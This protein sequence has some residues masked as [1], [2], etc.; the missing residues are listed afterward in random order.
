[1][2]LKPHPALIPSNVKYVV[3]CDESGAGETFGSMFLGC[4]AI[5]AEKLQ[6]IKQIFDNPNIKELEEFEIQDKYE[7]IRKDCELFHTKCKATEI[8]RVGKNTLL[9]QKYEELI[10][11]ATSGKED[12]CIIID[13]YG[14]KRGL[15]SFLDRLQSDGNTIIVENRADEK[16]AACQ[17]ASV[18]ARKERLEEVQSNNEKYKIRDES[19]KIIYPDSGNAGNPQTREYLE[20]FM[21]IHPKKELPSF[22]RKKWS[23]V[24]KLLQEKSNQKISEFFEG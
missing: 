23:N 5:E 9:D 17:A 1:M 3:G 19:G 13:D 18:I 7:Q 14:V 21:R 8:D 22:V 15:K 11:C 12:A 2:K 4:V 10:T 6:N 20:A 16:Y 24:E